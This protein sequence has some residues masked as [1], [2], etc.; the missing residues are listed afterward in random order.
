MFAQTLRAVCG[1]KNG[2]LSVGPSEGQ[3]SHP[4]AARGISRFWSDVM[5]AQPVIMPAESID[6]RTAWRVQ[7]PALVTAAIV[8]AEQVRGTVPGTGATGLAGE[9][10]L[11]SE[12]LLANRAELLSALDGFAGTLAEL[13]EF[14]HAGDGAA[15]QALLDAAAGRPHQGPR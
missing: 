8:R 5:N 6:R 1:G 15:M 7:L 11:Q 14:L 13:R 12:L 9:A 3:A 2:S 4:N 10:D